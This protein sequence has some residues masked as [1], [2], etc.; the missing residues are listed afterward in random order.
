MKPHIPQQSKPSHSQHGKKSGRNI[1]SSDS[2]SQHEHLDEK[3]P[4]SMT[5][6]NGGSVF[7]TSQILGHGRSRVLL[8]V[9]N[10]DSTVQGGDHPLEDTS[11][12]SMSEDSVVEAARNITAQ[13]EEVKPK[14]PRK[15]MM[16]QRFTFLKNQ[17]P[18]YKLDKEMKRSIVSTMVDLNYWSEGS[19]DDALFEED[20]DRR[21]KTPFSERRSDKKKESHS[22][23]QKTISDSQNTSQGPETV[24]EPQTNAPE[25]I[26]VESVQ[27]HPPT[28]SGKKP[29][30]PRKSVK[31]Y[32]SSGKQQQTSQ[33]EL[34]TPKPTK[35]QKKVII[36][37]PRA[38]K[39]A[40]G[41]NAANQ[42]QQ[43]QPQSQHQPHTIQ[44]LA[45][46]VEVKQ[47]VPLVKPKQIQIAEPVQQKIEKYGKQAL[48]D[49]NR[50]RD[51]I[52]NKA[53]Q[54]FIK[55]ENEQINTKEVKI[56]SLMKEKHEK[57]NNL[58]KRFAFGLVEK[59]MKKSK[60][61]TKEK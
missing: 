26:V 8:C 45:E 57:Q 29:V 39:K 13:L 38:N 23:S 32:H 50:I 60:I 31:I 36:L 10:D 7:H 9:D 19:D 16:K 6:P 17:M 40:P 28:T 41:G 44:E 15:T 14:I 43:S 54:I 18:Q 48:L 25:E 22:E 52:I 58:L 35:S 24:T 42:P 51:T 59:A 56:Q 2:G 5:S 34:E 3:R 37:D 33:D 4:M 1:I 61:I 49:R 30:D 27:P 55:V 46:P 21:A 11:L 12:F 47:K 53:V 20:E